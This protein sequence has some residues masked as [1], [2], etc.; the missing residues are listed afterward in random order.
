[1]NPKLYTLGKKEII[2]GFKSFEYILT[3]CRKLEVN[4]LTA[5]INTE[6]S[7]TDFPV[8]VGFLLSKKKLKNHTTVTGLRDF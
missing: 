8:K 5:F 2:R 3:H 6:I 7:N 1:M 4:N